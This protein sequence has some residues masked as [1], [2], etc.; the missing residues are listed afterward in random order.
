MFFC[1]F[2]ACAPLCADLM[3]ILNFHLF[4][5]DELKKKKYILEQILSS[6]SI[7]VCGS[8]G[9]GKTTVIGHSILEGEKD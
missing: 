1:A 8:A 5:W 2:P 6:K 4:V 7:F 9:I 3:R